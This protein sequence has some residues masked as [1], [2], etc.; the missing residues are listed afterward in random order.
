[1]KKVVLTSLLAVA[2]V[3]AFTPYTLAQDA[4]APAAG[5]AGATGQQV[6]LPPDEF[7]V[8][9]AAEGAG[10]P[11]AKVAA[12]KAYLQKYPNSPLKASVLTDIL[13]AATQ[14]QDQ[15]QILDAS[16]QLLAVDPN[17]LRA[18][19]FEVYYGKAD[20]DKLTDPTAKQAALDK[21]AGYAQT[22]LTVDKGS[23][24]K[25]MADADFQQL[26][27]RTLPV[28]SSALAADDVAKKDNAAA[29]QVIKD[30]LAA[31]PPDQTQSVG[32]VLQDEYTLANAYMNS[33][34]PDYLN[35]AWYAARTGAFAPAAQKAN[36]QQLAAYCY[37]KYHGSQEGF[38]KLQAQ[39]QATLN[40][41]ADLATTVTP[42]P[43]PEDIVKN[44]IATTPDLATLAL[45][46][47]EFV[48]QYGQP[49]DADKVFDTIKGKT[50]EIPG[51]VVVAAT[52]DQLQVAVSDDAKNAQ[53]KTADFTIAMKTPLTTPP[54]VGAVINVSGTY[55]SY[56]QTPLMIQMSDGA[57]VEKKEA[58]KKATTPVRRR[59]T[60]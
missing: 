32:P 35:C 18:L 27:S 48:L 19:A 46:D 6:T 53:P 40:P 60:H 41:P 7:N 33:T 13:G 5:A 34:P 50:V 8:Y 22:G 9:Q 29:I 52:T 1:M 11:A 51:A 3:A 26:K 59:T 16:S 15:A 25:G 56:T 57:V 14:T 21:V 23:A 4:S 58:P 44:L 28:F 17:N 43:K 54:A 31:V 24:P 39:A 12:L 38:D 10:Q 49:A 47:K 36:I 45:S 42:A 20:A 37:G 30:E 55:A 2:G